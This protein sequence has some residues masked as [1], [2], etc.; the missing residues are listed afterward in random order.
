M[1]KSA[2]FLSGILQKARAGSPFRKR[3]AIPP[4]EEK[5]YAPIVV[6]TPRD[7][8]R[9]VKKGKEDKRFYNLIC[10]GDDCNERKFTLEYAKKIEDAPYGIEDA[11]YVYELF[12]IVSLL[13]Q[14]GQ[15][16]EPKIVKEHELSRKL[17]VPML[18]FLLGHAKSECK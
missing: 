11:Y 9:Y 17:S 4:E 16:S 12:A 14:Y 1:K 6:Q 10:D 18:R 13:Q 7:G 3:K 5:K 15:E 2:E 8:H